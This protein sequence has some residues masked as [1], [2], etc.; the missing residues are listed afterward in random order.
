M[1]KQLIF[2]ILI[3]IS[4]IHLNAQKFQS[5]VIEKK[6][7]TTI[8]AKIKIYK[9]DIVLSAKKITYQKEDQLQKIKISEIERVLLGESVYSPFTSA[10]G[11]TKFGKQMATGPVMLYRKYGVRPSGTA[12][13][14]ANTAPSGKELY[15]MDFIVNDQKSIW[16][17]KSNLKETI[18]KFFPDCDP[19]KARL[20]R[21]NSLES[22]FPVKAVEFG[23]KNCN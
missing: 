14:G 13:F 17:A 7:G 23:N 9:R 20:R 4:A 21:S 18:L 19:L 10:N 3:L 22:K 2:T 15:F 16:I 1:K 8:E 12:T 6:D 5:G 11:G